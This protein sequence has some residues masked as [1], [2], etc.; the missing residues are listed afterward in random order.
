M[1]TFANGVIATLEAS[2]TINAPRKTGPSPKQNTV[3]R[4][5]VVGTRGEI[6]DQ[7]FRSP[8]RAVLAAG[9]ADWVFE[10]QSE[11][12]FNPPSPF[13]L[14]HL[15]E[16]LENDSRPRDDPRRAPL[17]CG[18]DGRL[19]VGAR[20]RAVYASISFRLKLATGSWKP[21]SGRVPTGCEHDTGDTGGEGGH[22]ALPIRTAQK[23]SALGG[24]RDPRA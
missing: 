8:G 12:P 20:G 3:V 17:L 5:E 6:V 9:A 22:P 13:P 18:R 4:L 2:W 10:R 16:C 14:P 19:R 1:F 21:A 7:W 23:S 15:I 11:P 24:R